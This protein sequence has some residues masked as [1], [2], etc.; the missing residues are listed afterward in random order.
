MVVAYKPEYF[1]I[2]LP[3]AIL[4][5]SAVLYVLLS[6]CVVIIQPFVS[7]DCEYA[8]SEKRAIEYKNPEYV[9]DHCRFVR[10]PLLMY[11]TVEEC[12]FA[13]RLLSATLFGCCIGWERR[14]ADRPAGIRT[15]ALVSLGSCLFSICSTFAFWSGPMNWD[16]ARVSAA[17]PSGVGFLGSAL[18]FK[19]T[20]AEDN[21]W[22]EVHGLT[23]AASVWLSAAVGIACSGALYYIAS[24]TTAIV[25]VMLRFG[26]RANIVMDDI[27]VND[28]DDEVDPEEALDGVS[29]HFLATKYSS[30]ATFTDPEY[31]EMI[32]KSPI[33][34]NSSRAS[35]VNRRQRPSLM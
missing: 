21:A 8:P 11:L 14:N 15:M 35:L 6:C 17:I 2:T 27:N 4:Y 16:S 26:P 9:Y 29:S 24:L 12:D 23:T 34:R 28:A 33:P 20:T 32:P 22:H 3:K 1:S 7:I 18:I 13:R 10:S 5:T 31:Q 30:I 19:H 25:L